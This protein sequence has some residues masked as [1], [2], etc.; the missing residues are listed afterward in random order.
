MNKRKILIVLL[1]ILALCALALII[2][3]MFQPKEYIPEIIEPEVYEDQLYD[4][5]L[6]IGVWKSGTL[7]YKFNDDG[8]GVTWDVADDVNELEGS[9]FTWEVDKKRFIHYH[10]MEINN[11]IIPKT[12]NITK[13]DLMNLE[14][15]DDFD[16]K[17]VFVKV[18]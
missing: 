17:Y 18:Q 11:A 14:Y 7:F 1:T 6:L 15:E 8:S 5:D 13:L 12:Y 16:V 3:K 2:W 4:T 9:K 10:K